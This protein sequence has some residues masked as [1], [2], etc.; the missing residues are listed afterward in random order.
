VARADALVVETAA[1]FITG[2]GE[3]DLG[4]ERLDLTLVAS[5]KETEVLVAPS[6]LRLRG[7]LAEPEVDGPLGALPPLVEPG[8]GEDAEC[9]DLLQRLSSD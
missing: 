3:V 2:K 9:R 1:A 5:P 4:R 7:S 6:P 8:T